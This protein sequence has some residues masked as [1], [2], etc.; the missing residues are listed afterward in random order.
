MQIRH[1]GSECDQLAEQR[2]CLL[3]V[4]L[5]EDGVGA[6]LQCLVFVEDFVVQQV[7]VVNVVVVGAH[8]HARLEVRGYLSRCMGDRRR[9]VSCCS[10]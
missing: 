10:A 2:H 5:A 3:Q 1:F 7:A 6:C 8:V 4:A 9:C